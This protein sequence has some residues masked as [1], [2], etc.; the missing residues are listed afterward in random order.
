MTAPSGVFSFAVNNVASDTNVAAV[1]A[2]AGTEDLPQ[3]RA[4]QRRV[5]RA[6]VDAARC[7]LIAN[8]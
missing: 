1:G 2:A 5:S 3:R 8:K 7:L 4:E 6:T